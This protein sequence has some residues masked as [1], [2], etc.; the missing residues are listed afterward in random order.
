MQLTPF[1]ALQP[2]QYLVES[3]RKF[4]KQKELEGMMRQAG[5]HHVSHSDILGGVVAIHSGFKP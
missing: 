2:Y 1:L 3:I 4:P 5:M